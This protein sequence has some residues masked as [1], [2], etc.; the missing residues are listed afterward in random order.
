LIC[1]CLKVDCTAAAVYHLTVEVE[2][3]TMHTYACADHATDL[4]EVRNEVLKDC[5][6]ADVS[7]RPLASAGEA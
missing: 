5:P 1:P 4:I 2:R 3:G 7:I 6:G